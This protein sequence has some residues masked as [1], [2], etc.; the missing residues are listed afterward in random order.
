MIINKSKCSKKPW[1]E[2]EIKKIWVDNYGHSDCGYDQYGE[3]ICCSDFGL[4]NGSG[5]EIHH[6]KSCTNHGTDDFSNLQPMHWR[7]HYRH[8][9]K[10]NEE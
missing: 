10:K 2:K 7:S 3:W 1:T 5:W 9:Q 6:I 4:K 8:H